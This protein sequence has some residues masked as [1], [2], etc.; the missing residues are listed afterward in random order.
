MEDFEYNNGV[1][2]DPADCN[3]TA[4]NKCP[5]NPTESP[6]CPDCDIPGTD[7]AETG[8]DAGFYEPTENT[9][10]EASEASEATVDPN[11]GVDSADAASELGTSADGNDLNELYGEPESESENGL[12][13][14]QNETA[15]T[16]DDDCTCSARERCALDDYEII[17]DV[18]GSEKQLVKLYSTA[19]C[20]SAEEPLRDVVKDNLI[21]C[22]RDQYSTFEYMQKRGLYPLTQATEEE[23]TKAKQQFESIKD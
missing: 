17:S 10:A 22:A 23:I 1:D 13:D 8:A 9:E 16:C 7:D 12:V 4:A 14:P 18:L 6:D 20:E 15:A 11:Y 19:L 21:E 3:M 5:C 2:C